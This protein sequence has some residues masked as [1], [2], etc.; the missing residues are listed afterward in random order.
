MNRKIPGFVLCT[1]LLALWFP[2][3]AQQSKKVPRVGIL[4]ADSA[5]TSTTRV[6]AFRQGLRDLGYVEG[7][8]ITSEYR[9]AEGV[10][11]RFPN[12]AAE[13]VQLKVD[14]IMLLARQQLKPPRMLRKQ[15]P[16][17]C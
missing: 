17:S 8:S 13:L 4:I 1:F 15:F 2:V 12:L 11:D 3:E 16:S 9:F 6:E 14:V 5:S 7:S 10:N